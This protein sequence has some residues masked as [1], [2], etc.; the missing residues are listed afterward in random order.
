MWFKVTHKLGQIK[1]SMMVA[2]FISG[3]SKNTSEG[4]L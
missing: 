4:F 2:H 1:L 3:I